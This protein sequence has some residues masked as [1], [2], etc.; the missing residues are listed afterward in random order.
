[1]LVKC[2][3]SEFDIPDLL[4]NKF[5]KDFEGLPGNRNYDSIVT[6]RECI[7]TIID[8][9][10]EYPEIIKEDPT[11]MADFIRALAMKKAMEQHGIYYDA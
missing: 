2:F 6:L 11:Q 3:D 7:G 5:V 9:V 1:M 10:A 4:V 8:V